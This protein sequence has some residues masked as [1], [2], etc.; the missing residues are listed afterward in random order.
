MCIVISPAVSPANASTLAAAIAATITSKTKTTM[1]ANQ[2]VLRGIRPS[3]FPKNRIHFMVAVGARCGW[4]H[5]ADEDTGS[6][7]VRSPAVN[8]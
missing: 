8:A 3:K 2:K 5:W 6:V 1:L 4:Q 7:R